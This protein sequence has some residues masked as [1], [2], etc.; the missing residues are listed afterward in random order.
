[1]VYVDTDREQTYP[2]SCRRAHTFL[3]PGR[4]ALEN[5]SERPDGQRCIYRR[6]ARLARFANNFALSHDPPKVQSAEMAA[7][8][9]HRVGP[10]HR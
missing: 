4:W 2:I 3:I 1:M 10:A 5:S 6:N 7:P 8:K 9:S